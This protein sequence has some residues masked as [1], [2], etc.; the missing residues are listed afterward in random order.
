MNEEAARLRRKA[1]A[2]RRIAGGHHSEDVIRDYTQ[3][4]RQYEQ[5]AAAVEEAEGMK[6][7]GQV[8]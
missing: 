3:L 7:S 1:S 4:A 5:L 8:H 2:C 6:G